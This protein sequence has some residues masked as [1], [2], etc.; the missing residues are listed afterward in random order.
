MQYPIVAWG[1]LRAGLTIVNTNPLY[2]KRELIY[3]FNDSGAK[4]LVSLSGN[5][6]LIA[7]FLSETRI[8]RVI[9]TNVPDM[10]NPQPL[11]ESNLTG[12]VSLVEALA[13]GKEQS[14]GEVALTLDHIALL[15]YAG[16]N[17]GCTKGG[18]LNARHFACGGTHVTGFFRRA[19]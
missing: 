6:D 19:N 7:E 9:A 16:G 17:D 10:L 5:L 13:S 14:L 3:Q 1:A 4:A 8:E 11:P 15:Q 2:T 12:A 18:R